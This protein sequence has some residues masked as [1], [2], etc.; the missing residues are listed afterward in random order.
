[1]TGRQRTRS[2][3]F[4]LCELAWLHRKITDSDGDVVLIEVRDIGRKG[5]DVCGT[6]VGFA[7]GLLSKLPRP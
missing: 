1:V 4:P 2:D 3:V 5:I 6:A 7:K